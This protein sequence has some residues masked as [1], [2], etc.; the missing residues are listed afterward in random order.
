LVCPFFVVVLFLQ[1]W[2]SP[3][4]PKGVP[5][6]NPFRILNDPSLLEMTARYSQYKKLFIVAHYNHPTELTG[7]GHR[8]Q[9]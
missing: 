9:L 7:A 4:I 3:Q 1:Q 2:T 8:F 6:F 5:A